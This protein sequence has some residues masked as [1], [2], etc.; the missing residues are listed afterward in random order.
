M[1]CGPNVL[2]GEPSDLSVANWVFTVFKTGPVKSQVDGLSSARIVFCCGLGIDA[3]YDCEPLVDNWRHNVLDN[4]GEIPLVVDLT[5]AGVCTE[6]A[7]AIVQ[8]GDGER[9]CDMPE[10][11]EVGDWEPVE[12]V[13]N[14]GHSVGQLAIGWLRAELVILC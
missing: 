4:R 6:Q 1:H 12:E 3:S 5:L 7:V 11:T 2:I 14:R 10:V 9:G 8:I 13:T